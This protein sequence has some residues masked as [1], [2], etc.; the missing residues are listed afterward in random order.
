MKIYTSYFANS[1]KLQEAGVMVIGIALNPPKWFRGITLK[2]AA[3]T[4]YI[5]YQV[6]DDA[7]YE[8]QYKRD[9]LGKINPKTFV[10]KIKMISQGK[11]VALCC[12]EKDWNDCHRKLLAEWLNSNTEKKIT[13]FSERKEPV[14]LNLF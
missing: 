4:P 1:R 6:K 8:R 10:E 3:P 11:D 9:I 12:F 2:E 14:E 5:L 13:E 7:E